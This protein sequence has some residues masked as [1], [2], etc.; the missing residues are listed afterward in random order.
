MI[1][2]RCNTPPL[3]IRKPP[4]LDRRPPG[5]HAT[6]VDAPCIAIRPGSR[7]L[8]QA[9]CMGQGNKACTRTCSIGVRG[10]P[11]GAL[12]FAVHPSNLVCPSP[13]KVQLVRG[14]F[15]TNMARHSVYKC[16]LSF[17][18]MPSHHPYLTSSAIHRQYACSPSLLSPPLGSS[19]HRHCFPRTQLAQPARA[20]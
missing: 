14:L 12:I 15:A 16:C 7:S 5:R 6:E 10:S 19:R 4:A 9:M 17:A 18:A 20:S 1:P 11:H 3:P 8:V 13:Q 2:L